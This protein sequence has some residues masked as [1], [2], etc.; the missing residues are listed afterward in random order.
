MMK[1]DND[2][3]V[4]FDDLSLKD[5][6]LTDRMEEQREIYFR[7]MPEICT[8]RACLITQYHLMK[9][10]RNECLFDKFKRDKKIS[11]LDKAKAYRY[12]LENRAPIVTHSRSYEKGIRGMKPFEF[13]EAP[14][15]AGS[16]TTKFKGVPL[17]PEFLALT[18]WPELHNISHRK[19]NPY[20]IEP[21]EI[22]DLNHKVFP[23][24][25]DCTITEILRKEHFNPNQRD[26]RYS[27][28]GRQLNQMEI[29]ERLVFFLLSK[30]D[31]IS[32]AIPDFSR[33]LELGLGKMI[34]EAEQDRDKAGEEDKKQ[35]YS[36]VCEALRESS[37][38]QTTWPKKPRSW[39]VRKA[40]PACGKGSERS[41]GLT[42]ES[43][44]RRQEVFGKV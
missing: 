3:K 5:W 30:P 2:K 42:A 29:L 21:S 1:S 4:T 36:A 25:M 7:A 24:W 39:P 41:P 26:S 44:R 34:D 18:L 27:Y 43:R 32:H 9:D 12:V 19:M 28:P 10:G 37:N 13:K 8:E 17:Y 38:I 35:F 14:L 22:E 23:R 20:H 40:I 31:S 11:I 15:F 16:T 6:D 33:V